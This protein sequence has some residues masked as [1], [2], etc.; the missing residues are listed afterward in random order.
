MSGCVEF[1]KEVEI[2]RFMNLTGG[3][4]GGLY[5]GE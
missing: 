3:H 2:V 5:E 1:V 4:D